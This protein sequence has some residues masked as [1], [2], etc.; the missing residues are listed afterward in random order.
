V[1]PM[2]FNAA[3]SKDKRCCTGLMMQETYNSHS[4]TKQGERA[5]ACHCLRHYVFGLSINFC[6]LI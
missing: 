4:K 5:N 2:I 1:N 6:N 3:K